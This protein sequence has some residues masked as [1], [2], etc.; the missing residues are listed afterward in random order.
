MKKNYIIPSTSI[1]AFR[2]G[3]ICQVSGG[4]TLNI[5]GPGIGSGGRQDLGDPD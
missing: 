1:V 4:P 5:A 3:S 2:A